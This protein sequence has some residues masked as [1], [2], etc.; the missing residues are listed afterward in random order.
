MQNITQMHCFS[1][2]YYWYNGKWYDTDTFLQ[3]G[4]TVHVPAALT[5][6]SVV[7]LAKLDLDM[8]QVH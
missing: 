5:I 8:T 6:L 4:L 2:V 3:Q 7:K 1:V